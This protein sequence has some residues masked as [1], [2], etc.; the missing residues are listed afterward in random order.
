MSRD[1]KTQHA[2]LRYHLGPL[3]DQSDSPLTLAK[4]IPKFSGTFFVWLLN[5]IFQNITTEVTI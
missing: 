1:E 2:V 4:M 5:F 3:K